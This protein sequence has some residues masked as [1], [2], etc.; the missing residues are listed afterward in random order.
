[1][2]TFY[3]YAEEG[4]TNGGSIPPLA[5]QGAWDGGTSGG[6]VSS[7]PHQD[8]YGCSLIPRCHRSILHHIRGSRS[9][10]GLGAHHHRCN[11]LVK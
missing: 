7:G 1:M 10:R 6:P 2:Y 3:T 4:T 5:A 8:T 9:P 11:R